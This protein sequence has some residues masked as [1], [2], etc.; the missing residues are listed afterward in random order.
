M[1]TN[2]SSSFR[3]FHVVS[4]NVR[5][6]GDSDK[7]NVVRNVLS[8]AKPSFICIQESKLSEVNFFKAQSFLPRPLSSSSVLRPAD[9]SRGGLITAWAPSLFTLNSHLSNPYSLTSSFSCN[10]SNFDI[11]ITNVYGPSDHSSTAPFLQEIRDIKQLVSGAWLLI[12]D[13]NLVRSAADKSN[14][15]FNAGLAAAFNQ[16]IQE[17]L[18]REVDLSD[19]RFTWTNK[20]SFPILAMLDRVFTN[21][22]LDLVFPSANLSSLPRP[23]SDHTPL[24]LS[25]SS[26]IPKTHFFRLDNFLLRNESFLN[27]VIQGWQQAVTCN[28]AA[29]QLV[30]C[31]KAARA[32]AKV[33]KRCNRAPPQ[34][35]QNCHFLMRLFDYFEESRALSQAEFQVR[36]LAQERLQQELKAK[37]AYWRQRS[38]QKIIKECDANTAYHHAHATLQMR[39]K[40]IRMVRVNNQEVVSHAGKTEALS[41][42]FKSIIGVPGQMTLM[43]LEAIYAGLPRPDEDISGRFSEGELKKAVL[44]MNSLSAPGPDGFGPAFF[45]VAWP[46]VKRTIVDFA[47][48]F[49]Q[50]QAD[51]ERINRSHMVLLPKKPNAVDVDAFR[52]ICLQNSALKILTKALTTRLQKQIPRLIDIHQTGFVKGRSITDTF[53]YAAELVQTCH[54]RRLPTIVLKLDFA[55]AFDTVIWEGLRRV[56]QARGF[57]Q[58]WIGWMLR[59]LVSSKSA[60]LVNG[61]P[62]PWITCKRGLR[63]GDPLS[64]YLFILVAETLQRM[65]R[66]A[67]Q[68]K[69]PTDEALP[70]A[71][72]Q[73]ADDT[74]IVFRAD[75]AGAVKLKEILDQFAAFS[76]LHINFNK[77]TL[78]P[79]HANEQTISDCVQ[80]I[81]CTKGSFPQPYLGLPLSANKLPVSSFN[82]YIQKADKFLGS[83]QAD[84]L[85]PM[86]R[87]VL[88]NSVLDSILVYLMSSLQLPPSAIEQM[89]KKRR[90][91]LWSGDKSGHSTPASCL[92]AWFNICFPKEL[93]GLGIRDLGVQ[94]ICLL[95]KLLHC[96]QSSAWAQWVQGRATITTLQGDL[97]GDHWQTLRTLLPLY[98]AITTV[99]IGD[100]GSC[101]LWNDVWAGEECLAD[102]YPAIYSHCNIKV[103]TVREAKLSGIQHTLVPRLSAIAVQEM[104]LVQQLIDRTSL[105]Q[106]PDK[107]IS[108]FINP[109]NSLDTSALYKMIKARGQPSDPR[110]IFIWKSLAPPRVKLFM[111]L[112]LQKRIQCRAVLLKKHIVDSAICLTCNATDET[113]E[114]I[115][116]G[117]SVGREVWTRLNLQ[118]MISMDMGQLHIS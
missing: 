25:L 1:N 106:A 10:A 116:H 22:P 66:D 11:T 38:K 117:C 35:I 28:D 98:H 69:H 118:S 45:R 30:A 87:A 14:G 81:G 3:R 72:L 101:S 41:T 86:G 111:W 80:I 109:D 26:D 93:G 97:H 61:H 49:H 68:I 18:V 6:L 76:G 5:G 91:F 79:I 43:D 47:E 42:F 112:L 31:I 105:S 16:T 83:W 32:A 2:S 19:R 44:A 71:V 89:D 104:H 82:I 73:Y 84:L 100:G 56:L 54:K 70:C 114:H 90:A 103:Q 99:E 108:D 58:R 94:N 63:Q 115:I 88:V 107:R 48:A 62:G 85:N 24:L 59:L 15:V 23:T 9:G 46:S 60:V 12:G 78:V 21:A 55:K 110:A 77:S 8:D 4:W 7:C 92:V 13:F 20:Q 74:L 37:A 57:D 50:G 75:V 36:S 52:P 65:I 113:P 64:P 102:K 33:W 39:R 29:G 51:L 53:V 96:P 67:D 40:F 27:S 95:L 34:I 17:V